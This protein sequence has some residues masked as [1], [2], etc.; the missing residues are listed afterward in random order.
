MTA[1]TLLTHLRELG[2]R[3]WVEDGQL[4]LSAPK[5]VLT[6]EMRTL[7][8]EY[9]A[10]LLNLLH[11][12]Q[13]ASV[14]PPIQRVP[15]DQP[16][17]LSFAQQRLWFLHQ[18][19][20]MS[21]AYHIPAAVE[22]LGSLHVA[23]L[24]R[25][26]NTIIG[27]HEVLRTTFAVVDG[28]PAQ[29]IA[30]QL[31]VTLS[32][33]DLRRLPEDQQRAEVQRLIQEKSRVPFDLEH[34]PL[35]RPLLLQVEDRRH[36]LVLTMHH[37]IA[38]GWS[39]GVLSNEL[40]ALYA[41][42]AAG[43]ALPQGP[44]A[45]PLDIQYADYSVWQRAWLQGAELERQL[46]YWK[47]QLSA[48]PAESGVRALQPLQLPTD[49][50]RPAIQSFRGA[51]LPFTLSATQ[52][53]QLKQLAQREQA[54]LFMALLAAFNVL[55]QRYTGQTDLLVGTPVA[56]RTTR[57]IEP[58]IGFFVNTLLIRTTI[59]DQLSFVAL[60]QQVRRT[61]IEAHAHQDLP[62][63]KIVEELRLERSPGDM[64]LLRVLFALQNLPQPTLQLAD[65]RM[66]R[67]DVDNGT[68]KVDLML[69]LTEGPDGITG[70][71][72]Y[73]TD[74][75]EPATIARMAEHFTILL[76]GILADPAAPLAAL[77][78][79]SATERRQLLETWNAT[80]TAYPRDRCIHELFELQADRTP[81]AIALIDGEQRLSYAE[82]DRRA[83]QLA[84]YLLCH[85]VGAE[86]RIG[87]CVERAH[88]L[89]IGLLAILK[90]GGCY[91]PLDPSYP[92][93]R[94]QFML[95]DT[96]APLVITTEA[97]ATALPPHTARLIR[98]DTDAAR[99]AQQP[100]TTPAHQT[101]SEY[102]AYVIYTSGS[103]GQPKGIGIPH[104]AI[105]RL[106]CSTNYV[107]LTP[108]HVIALLSNSSFDAATFELWGALS[109]GARLIGVPREVAL[110]PQALAAHI[111]RYEITTLF[112]TTAL[113]NQIA[114]EV[115]DAFATMREVMFGGEASDPRSVAAV[116]AA[117]GPQRLLHVYGPTESTTFASWYEV[118]EVPPGA[119]TIPIGYPLANTQLYVLDDQVQP[120]PIGVSGELYIGGD[121]LA[122]SYLN[123]PTLTAEKFIPDPF[124]GI[125]GARLYRTGDVVRYLADGA[126]LFIGRR[127]QQ[128]KIRGFRIELSEIEA[129]LDTH[130]EVQA[131]V[132][133]Q[134]T[135]SAAEKRLVAY[136]VPESAAS[137]TTTAL[138]SF[139]S[140]RLPDYMLPS[141]FVL[142][143]GLPLTPNGKVDRRA[144][145]NPDG[146]R[147]AL[148]SAYVAPR[149]HVEERIAQIFRDVLGLEQV[150][151]N[152]HFFE[153]GGHSLLATQ[154]VSRINEHFAIQLPLINLFEGPTVAEIAERVETML[155][156]DIAE[157]PAP[158][159]PGVRDQRPLPLSFAQERLWFIQQL[160]PEQ[161]TYNMP[162]A[163]RLC[164]PLATEALSQGLHTIVQRHE[165]LRTSF[166]EV[167]GQPAQVIESARSIDL[168]QVDLTQL[169]S[170]DRA[171]ALEQAIDAEAYTPFDL[172]RAPL[173]RTVLLH[174][175]TDEQVLVLTMHHIVSDGWSMGV[176]V[177][178]LS[179]LYNALVHG[180]TPQLA[181]LPVQY[182]DFALWQR[183]WLRGPLL[184]RQ[185]AYWQQQL[186][187][188]VEPLELPTDRPRPALPSRAGARYSITIPAGLTQ[189]LRA[190]SQ[191]EEVTLFMTL[192]AAFST[193]LHRYTGQDEIVVGSAIANRQRAEI[194]PLIGFF[195][196]VLALKIRLPGRVASE[197]SFRDLLRDVRQVTLDGYSNQETPFE[198]LVE[199]LAPEREPGRNPLFQVMFS[200]QNAP[201]KLAQLHDLQLE[202][203][204]IPSRS[205]KFDLDIDIWERNDVLVANVEYA[206]ELFDAATIQR[207]MEH[208]SLLLEQ[209][210]AAPSAR[211]SELQIL[212]AD[213]Q[214]RLLVE[215]NAERVAFDVN[216]YNHER[217]A[218][219]AAD[220]P[221][222]VAIVCGAEQLSYAQLER[223]SNQLAHYLQARG[224]HVETRIGI[225]MER[226]IDLIVAVLGVWKAGATYVPLDPDYPPQRLQAMAERAQLTLLLSQ[227]Q[228]DMPLSLPGVTTLLLDREQEAIA[229]QPLRTPVSGLQ[230]ENLAYIIFTSGSTGQPKGVMVSHANLIAI[231]QSW[232]HAYQLDAEVSAHLQMASFSFDPWVSDLLRALCFGGK[233]VVCPRDVLLDPPQLYDL[234]VR[235]RIDY[236]E[237]VPAVLR[238]LLRYLDQTG[239]M[240]PPMKMLGVGAD[241]WFM[242][243]HR[244][245]SK[246]LDPQTQLVNSY[247]ITET[248]IDSTFFRQHAIEQ[249]HD[250]Q[251]LIGRPFANVQLYVLDRRLQ[252]VPIGVAG[253]LYIGGPTL[254][255]GYVEQPTITAERFI[256]HPF[257][258]TPGARLYR[259]GDRVRYLADGTLEYLGRIDRQ[260]K[261]RGVRL[262]LGEV[263]AALRQH[264][265]VAEAIVVVR[266]DRPGDQ[267]LVAYAL[268]RAEQSLT[269]AEIQHFLKQKLPSAVVPQAYVLL[270]SLPLTP[271]GKLDRRALPRPDYALS[272]ALVE[273]P[274]TSAEQRIAAICA[275]VLGID[276][277]TI[278][279]SLFDLGCHSL[280]AT[281]IVSRIREE[282]QVAL[283]LRSFFEEPTVAQ[284]AERVAELRRSTG[285]Y[286]LPPIRRVSRDQLLPLSFAQQRLWF[287]DQLE[288]GNP[289]YNV[290]A[291]IRVQGPLNIPALE[292]TLNQIV[293]RHEVLRTTFTSVKGQPK[294]QINPAQ[295][296]TLAQVDLTHI[297]PA[298]RER[299]ARQLAD[300][301]S[302]Q[303]FDLTTGP[304][305][306]AQ[307]LR[308]DQEEY[309][310]L[311]TMHHIVSDAWSLGILI[312][313]MSALYEAFTT[314]QPHPEHTPLLDLPV[315]Y[316]DFA[317]WQRDW[318][319]GEVLEQQLDYWRNQM[320]GTL[321]VLQLPT[322]Y[323]R[324]P[325][326]TFSGAE[327]SIDLPVELVADLR[328]FSRRQQVTPFMALLAAFST[329]LYRYTGQ[330]D[331]IVGS[332]IASR[333]VAELEGLIGF[334]ANMLVLR[335]DLSGNPTFEELLRRVRGVTLGAYA[336]QDVPFEKLVAELQPER[337]LSR[338]PLFQVVCALDN[339]P[340]P[341]LKLPNLKLQQLPTDS[342]TAM[343]EL[344]LG[345]TDTEAG[346]QASALYN[347]DL[348]KPATI[349]QMV[350]HIQAILAI[351]IADPGI[352]L[353]EIPLH[354]EGLEP[355][356]ADS[357]YH[358]ADAA[359]EFDF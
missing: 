72:E 36:V 196:N 302:H 198:K 2:A 316:G 354:P 100:T 254:S 305:I 9:K 166:I 201:L 141:L 308:L 274:R 128:V 232:N 262:E 215:W 324:P 113:F 123:Q 303:P 101:S 68:A 322:D 129:V 86:T 66:R 97:L 161:T 282:F 278:H 236:T 23:T 246:Y 347:T 108:E 4:R 222:R 132:V 126:L 304:L 30:P 147:P 342:G 212:S 50:P 235:E 120:V 243:E 252:P 311:I 33:V 189:Q 55:L 119:T 315:Q 157:Q 163:I 224:A 24:E 267:R 281:Q 328:E 355:V 269:V 179:T 216:S 22:L 168:K 18:L 288:P 234:L 106:V 181:P 158:I 160:E 46:D 237:F 148:E 208:Y 139:L 29:I 65:L 93:E 184:E 309:I 276:Q 240:L 117:G 279:E 301:E 102:L 98:L 165:I 352:R 341:P 69:D 53:D 199:L 8:A 231:C 273:G 203:V 317:V 34:G 76:A 270:S 142:L 329:L 48:T 110:A 84:H 150:G 191:H 83:N 228:L 127:D 92:A 340:I 12:A 195:V 268:P 13:S 118:A 193:L 350:E 85:G 42:Y 207:M 5:G 266:E 167:A 306:R 338:S 133:V 153:L 175:D 138:R 182:A 213:E 319:Q 250:Q 79:L 298:A 135:H 326:Q 230:P 180:Q 80:S 271:N 89:L 348:F 310:V 14:S 192:L 26:L 82:L 265:G 183:Q 40:S 204:D 16:L 99:W 226:S 52:T 114:R 103:T 176:L 351:V 197:G 209:I 47:Q 321:P 156:Q 190:L 38:D 111:R 358:N 339:A 346:M 151:S 257:S 264:P 115:P 218:A 200:L 349:L 275:A 292:Q 95:Q 143:P 229:R 96:A 202:L 63:E 1:I 105:T 146:E 41:A 87:I 91:V 335:T 54:T 140:A 280:L 299:A 64:P 293:Q 334:F 177:N 353:L 178:E 345:F 131:C 219:Q 154:A 256:P 313:E 70:W 188:G 185:L 225:C 283:P 210:V 90:A 359:Q 145:P 241:I 59:A 164:G 214:R 162:V 39:I 49:H 61:T 258:T 318:L 245:A 343:F 27:R 137:P 272:E 174:L 327:L 28:Q 307:V 25:A 81:A 323:P 19:D 11:T 227:A 31:S 296:L 330:D 62:F 15:R 261:L 109:H 43:Q 284:L 71:F 344:V 44:V 171:A 45:N 112:M 10:D 291:A 60:L 238:G 286:A 295:P 149:T 244:R 134:Q 312:W 20:P 170:A 247:G 130:P 88:E 251:I 331:L 17:P 332:P 125:L 205:A 35:I 221:E 107:Q 320:G 187:D 333:S 78:L 194:E 285:K 294:Q 300:Q 259:T 239:Q 51:K 217:I 94:I 136:V 7:L 336:H 73:S 152:D 77:P 122:Q 57:Q 6:P 242:S 297:D 169:P 356:D 155:G 260:V 277:V 263:E 206:T 289:F 337:N 159:L 124:S 67:L 3:L 314:G 253:E 290:P 248:T 56:Q 249:G 172:S 144:L 186:G 116:L 357:S 211:L 223:R 37:V 32:A 287:L 220:W 104:R 255:R 121:G 75:F 173:L 233:L 74:L 325:V 58:L 21:A